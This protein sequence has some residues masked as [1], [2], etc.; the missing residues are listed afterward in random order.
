M[1][2]RKTQ[3]YQL[4][5][6]G[7]QRDVRPC[8]CIPLPFGNDRDSTVF[9]SSM[10]TLSVTE[11]DSQP[12]VSHYGKVYISQRV[13]ISGP[14]FISFFFLVLV[15][16]TTSQNIGHFLTLYISGETIQG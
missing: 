11:V 8:Q 16:T 10:F 3:Q 1:K 2:C 7:A 12:N 14:M 13:Y 15:C 5:I 9:V 4:F 6:G